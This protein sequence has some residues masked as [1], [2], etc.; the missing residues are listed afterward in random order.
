MRYIN[1]NILY[2]GVTLE[3]IKNNFGDL[4]I[5][6]YNQISLDYDAMKEI[7]NDIYCSENYDDENSYKYN[8]NTKYLKFDNLDEQDN[9]YK[10]I[11][12]S[13]LTVKYQKEYIYVD[14][15]KNKKFINKIHKYLN[16]KSPKK[17]KFHGITKILLNNF[18]GKNESIKG[19]RDIDWKLHFWDA[20]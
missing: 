12:N 7:Y 2:F 4:I 16:K 19:I 3:D 17:L 10:Y 9:K 14:I 13:E 11:F 6:I 8:K 18:Y 1:D 5:Y 20:F 15:F